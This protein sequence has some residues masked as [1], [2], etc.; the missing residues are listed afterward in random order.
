[1]RRTGRT[2]PALAAAALA[3]GLASAPASALAAPPEAPADIEEMPYAVDTSNQAAWWKPID[4]VDGHDYLAFNAPASEAG[5]H[6]VHLARRTASGEWTSGCL[7]AR[8]GADCV[9]YTDDIGHNQP[10]ITV[11]G[12]GRVHAFVSMHNDA[13]R[14]YRSTAPGDVDSLVESAAD[15]PDGGGTYT[16]PV[17]A[18]DDASGDV[19]ALVRADAA[20]RRHG[21]LYRWDNAAGE[22]SRETTV[23]SAPGHAFYPDDL[24]VDGRGR[25][26]VLW[27]WGPFP[28]STARH[29][30]SYLVYDPATGTAA[31]AAGAPV[32]LPAAADPGGAVVYQPYTEGEDIGTQ[33]PSLQSAK[34]ALTPEGSLA[35]VA[36]RFRDRDTGDGFSG[37][38]ARYARWTGTAWEREVLAEAGAGGVHT[39]AAID[40]T[41]ADGTTR[42]YLVAEHRRCAGAFSQVVRAER[43]GSGPWLLDRAGPERPGLQ[44]L[45]ALTGADG[46]DTLYVSAP[47]AEGTRGSVFRIGLSRGTPSG[48]GT[49]EELVSGLSEDPDLGENLALGGA[50]SVSSR[51]DADS[52]GDRAVD[53]DCSDASRWI[54]AEGDAEPTLTVDPGAVADVSAVRVASGYAPDPASTVLR[55]FEVRG[56]TPGGGWTTLASVSGNTE[57]LRV[58]EFASAE[59]DRVQLVVTDPSASEVD[60]ARVREFQVFS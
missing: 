59:V 34:L 30:G 53:G 35:G 27:E 46:A 55:D 6:E 44:R 2:L 58:V 9:S 48:G 56:R 5:R 21:R 47:L 8:A 11:D 45:S 16:Y 36:Y 51:R 7:R 1:M 29:L 31:D 38:D 22:W 40:T 41:H 60:V 33:A 23:A 42:V 3:A 28:S 54:S 52:G 19:Y 15:L 20:D 12:D 43:S 57:E 24:E 18:R 26:H 25:V 37:Y 4:S 10:S 32:A 50:T 39:S 17:T 13:W 49:W 14:Y